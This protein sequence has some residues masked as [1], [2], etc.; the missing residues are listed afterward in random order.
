VWPTVDS[1]SLTAGTSSDDSSPGITLVMSQHQRRDRDTER[2]HRRSYRG[3]GRARSASTCG[4]HADRRTTM[5]HD[6]GR[7]LVGPPRH[8]QRRHRHRRLRPLTTS[9]VSV[10]IRASA[11][12]RRRHASGLHAGLE[13]VRQE[14][15]SSSRIVTGASLGSTPGEGVPSGHH[16]RLF[17]SPCRARPTCTPASRCQPERLAPQRHRGSRRTL[18]RDP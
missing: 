5:R 11:A 7:Q 9:C 8:L 6:R 2:A 12:F 14:Q 17:T 1:R 15:R 4:H 10:G 18:G 3:P 13:W 16:V